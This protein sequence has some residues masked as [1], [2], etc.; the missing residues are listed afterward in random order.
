ME[1]GGKRIFILSVLIFTFFAMLVSCENEYHP[2]V[3]GENI[4]QSYEYFK[5]YWERD[6]S[7]EELASFF[8]SWLSYSDTRKNYDID[9]ADSKAAY[10]NAKSEFLKHLEREKSSKVFNI[11]NNIYRIED[12]FDALVF[13]VKN[14]D[15]D[16][17]TEIFLQYIYIRGEIS[18]NSGR[19]YT[20]LLIFLSV[21]IA[22]IIVFIIIYQRIFA[23]MKES[24][25]TIQITMNTQE[26]ERKRISLELHDSVAQ[27]MRYISMLADSLGETE[28]VER[29]KKCIEDIRAICN[30]L[31]PVDIDRQNLKGALSFLCEDF[32]KKSGIDT[33]L[34]IS[35]DVDF[36]ALGLSTEQMHNI[37]RIIQ[38]L[39]SNIKKYADATEVTVLLRK[40][41][42]LDGAAGRNG[43]F[44]IFIT[45]DGNGVF[46]KSGLK[47]DDE[48]PHFGLR[49]INSRLKAL[50]ATIEYHRIKGNGTD[51]KITVP[52]Q[53]NGGGS[54]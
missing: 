39:L 24:E 12:K 52:M 28:I 6:K 33:T 17:A 31:S 11:A 1:N 51:V 5:P 30:N 29:Q 2:P 8:N 40:A 22:L 44:C 42:E 16:L 14:D 34:A 27:E 41:S 54:D 15:L 25:K 53:T 37:F 9:D 45:D 43:G 20:L 36:S 48:N 46:K 19:T 26:I 13:A 49:N 35:D 7:D 21:A 38:E 10:Q 18:R 32:M 50:S 47:E 3:R 4:E 23:E